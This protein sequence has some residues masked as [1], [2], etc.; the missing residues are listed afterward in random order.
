MLHYNPQH[1]S[2]IVLLETYDYNV[3]YILLYD[4]GIVH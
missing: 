1:V 3:K 2:S 4:K